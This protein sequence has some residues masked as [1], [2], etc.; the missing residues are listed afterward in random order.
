MKNIRRGEEVALDYSTSENENGWYLLCHCENKI[1]R[2][3]IRPYK[4]LSAELKLKYRDYTS[5]YLRSDK[6]ANLD[7][8]NGS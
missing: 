5:E 6:F 3:I 7:N 8:I 4:Y 2:R 1:C